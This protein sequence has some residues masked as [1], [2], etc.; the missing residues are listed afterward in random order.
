MQKPKWA[1]FVIALGMLAG[2]QHAGPGRDGTVQRFGSV[3]GL[4]AEKL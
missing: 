1:V 4:K 2:C 3:I